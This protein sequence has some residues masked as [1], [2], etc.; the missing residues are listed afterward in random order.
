[1][2]IITDTD[3]LTNNTKIVEVFL[4]EINAINHLHTIVSNLKPVEGTNDILIVNPN[5]IE[6]YNCIVGWTYNTRV[7]TSVFQLSFHKEKDCVCV[8]CS[9]EQEDEC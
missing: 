6:I 1:M 8:K 9:S 3:V 4:Y 2:Y 7:L 5:R